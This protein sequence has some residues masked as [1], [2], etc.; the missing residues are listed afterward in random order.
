LHPLLFDRSHDED[1]WKP[2]SISCEFTLLYFGP[3]FLVPADQ[4]LIFLIKI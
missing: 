1:Y 2:T 3:D 4:A